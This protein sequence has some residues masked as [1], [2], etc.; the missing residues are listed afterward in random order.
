M[1]MVTLVVP[2]TYSRA[3]TK[4]EIKFGHGARHYADFSKEHVTNLDGTL[5]KRVKGVDGL[6]YTRN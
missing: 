4:A 2:I 6:I 5:K 1:K 3:P